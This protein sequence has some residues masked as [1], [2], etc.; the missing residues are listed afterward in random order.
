MKIVCKKTF[1]DTYIFIFWSKRLV[2][3]VTEL[4][5][6]YGYI[7][8][9]TK[10][11]IS[12]LSGSA[13]KV[14]LGWGG[15]P[16][17]YFV[18]PNLSWGW[19]EAVTIIMLYRYQY[20]YWG[21][22]GRGGQVTPFFL[23]ISSSWVKIRLHTENQLPGLS[24]SALKVWLGW[25][26]GVGWGGGPTDYF[27]TLNLSW[28]WVEAVTIFYIFCSNKL[29]GIERQTGGQTDKQLNLLNVHTQ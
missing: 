5:V 8:L 3:A 26:G 13:L 17:D 6:H 2:C 23:H 21:G 16:T 18:T 7:R 19:V 12:R 15:G 14:W 25:V 9:H 10:N 28:G 11:Q 22:E 27:I 29:E 20:I 24:G 4:S 1:Y